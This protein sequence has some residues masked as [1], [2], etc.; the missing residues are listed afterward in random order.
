M[1]R[2]YMLT[3]TSEVY[4]SIILWNANHVWTDLHFSPKWRR[5]KT[6]WQEYVCVFA[7]VSWP[8]VSL[9]WAPGYVWHQLLLW[10]RVQGRGGPVHQLLS[11]HCQVSVPAQPMLSLQLSL[12]WRLCVYN[13]WTI[14]LCL[15]LVWW[16]HLIMFEHCLWYLPGVSVGS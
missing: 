11:P 2:L 9:W 6:G 16:R 15:V 3:H 7:C 12:K 13:F 8:L 10:Q 5:F 4:L 14:F 1:R